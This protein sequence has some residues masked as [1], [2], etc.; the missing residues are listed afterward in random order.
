MLDRPAKSVQAMAETSADGKDI[1]RVTGK[2]HSILVQ[3]L[4]IQPLGVFLCD[5]YNPYQAKSN[6]AVLLFLRPTGIAGCLLVCCSIYWP[7]IGRK[8][9]LFPPN[10]TISPGVD[11]VY[12]VSGLQSFFS[13]Y[14]DLR[15]FTYSEQ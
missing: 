12:S 14:I 1:A 3:C 8:P 4:G 9:D 2:L 10:K 6:I 7:R 13:F 15:D 5:N 11:D